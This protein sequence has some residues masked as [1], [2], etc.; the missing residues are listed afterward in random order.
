MKILANQIQHYIKGILYHDQIDLSQENKF[1][2]T[3]Q[4]SV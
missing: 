4:K 1:H 3:S 2:L